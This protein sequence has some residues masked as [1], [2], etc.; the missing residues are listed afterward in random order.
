MTGA[1]EFKSMLPGR[2]GSWDADDVATT[3]D[4][5]GQIGIRVTAT[6]PGGL[7]VTDTFF[8]DVIPPN[9]PPLATD[10]TYTTP[11]NVGLTTL[12]S[13]GVLH[14]DIDP[15]ADPFTAALVT[16]PTN[17][18]L[19]FHADG[20]FVYI[21][22]HDFVGTDTFTYQDTDSA[23]AV[24]NIATATINVVNAGKITVTPTAPATTDSVTEAFT[25]GALPGAGSLNFGW[26]TSADGVAWTPTGV[27][28]ATFLPALTGPTGIFLRG[29][30]SYQ[31][32]GSTISVT[33]D[34]V[35]YIS[36]NDLGD[37]MSGT[38]GNN[39]IF[40]NGGDDVIAAGIGSLL[41]YGGDGNDRFVATVG[42]GVA[43]FD[44]QAGVNTLD[45]SQLSTDATVNLV[46]GT[47][48]SAQTGAAT[49]V[50][51]Q[52]V[53]SGLGNDTITG[54][55]N[56]NTFFAAVGDGNDSYT[57]GGGTDTYDLS[58]TAAGATVNLGLGTA[59]SADTGTDTLVGYRRT[60][61][62]APATT[63][64]WPTPATATT[65]TTAGSGTDTYDLSATAAAATVNLR[66]PAYRPARI[67]APTRWPGSRTWSAVRATTR[68]P[69]TRTGQR[70]HRRCR[71]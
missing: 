25:A 35:Y 29:T 37:A 7:S 58:R 60:W 65:A 45:L 68:S 71:C 48:T 42:D 54:D 33:S 36:D 17:G 66:D 62:A 40:A 53:V 31:N 56:N 59:T 19:T 18:T 6:D 39:I 8:I 51:I 2:T 34:P 44:G 1:G 22:N 9:S 61:S 32:A 15:N 10:D 67:P 12:P 50:S 28:S 13:T 70:H 52:N 43:T 49:L 47:A 24:S 23:N 4:T 21:P 26:D 5:P 57:G 46:T 11:V 16:G 55:A 30:A 64:S 38:S 63:A 41:A 20:T 3:L 69:A 14:N 27:A